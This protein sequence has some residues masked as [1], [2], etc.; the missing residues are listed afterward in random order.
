LLQAE[1]VELE[2]QL[3]EKKQINTR[4]SLSDSKLRTQIVQLEDTKR[5][6][7]MTVAALRCENAALKKRPNSPP[8]SRES[9]LQQQAL[10]RVTA[11]NTRLKLDLE[12]VQ[13][14][15]QELKATH[16]RVQRDYQTVLAENAELK[17][18]R[19]GTA[20]SGPSHSEPTLKKMKEDTIRDVEGY[21]SEMGGLIDR[22]MTELTRSYEEYETLSAEYAKLRQRA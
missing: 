6:L 12:G 19:K 2:S 20:S 15:L 8:G 10:E 7:E 9:V 18:Q 22:L 16:A 1:I 17:L 11:E 5:E 13:M 4:L 3:R 14:D 21:T